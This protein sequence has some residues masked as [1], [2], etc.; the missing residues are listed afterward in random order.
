MIPTVT[1]QSP[2]WQGLARGDYLGTSVKLA[3]ADI[4]KVVGDNASS[5]N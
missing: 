4:C 3:E 2:F 5:I 1:L